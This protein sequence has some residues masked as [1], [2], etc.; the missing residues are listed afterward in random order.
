MTLYRNIYY[1]KSYKCHSG[2]YFL[3]YHEIDHTD[4]FVYHAN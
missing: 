3:T 2:A 1:I 4:S